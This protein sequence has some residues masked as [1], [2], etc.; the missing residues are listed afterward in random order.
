MTSL[1]SSCVSSMPTRASYP[2]PPSECAS[3]RP[4]DRRAAPQSC[5]IT[6]HGGAH[7]MRTPA[8]LRHTARDARRSLLP[9]SSGPFCSL[10]LRARR[11]ALNPELASAGEQSRSLGKLASSASS[12]GT[13]RRGDRVRACACTC[14]RPT[15]ARH[16][17][18]HGHPLSRVFV[19]CCSCASVRASVRPC[20]R[21]RARA[22]VR[23][24]R[25]KFLGTISRIRIIEVPRR[26]NFEVR[27]SLPPR[28]TYAYV[29]NILVVYMDVYVRWETGRGEVGPV[30]RCRRP[31]A[32]A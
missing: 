8:S 28:A 31:T 27:P 10:S 1:T 29:Y 19:R 7:T 18:V 9:R 26:P 11:K 20:V 6:V 16:V 13:M 25:Y 3:S 12:L 14:V 32:A 15:R 24:V 22:R 5:S 30:G 4:L 2:R 23:V 21:A 17:Q